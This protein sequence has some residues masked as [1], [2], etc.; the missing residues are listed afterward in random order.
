MTVVYSQ[1][2]KFYAQSARGFISEVTTYPLVEAGRQAAFMARVA[3]VEMKFLMGI[4]AG[5]SGVG[6]ALVI[7]T[8]VAEF[9]VQNRENFLKW[10]SQLEAVLKAREFLKAY[11]PKLYEKVFNAVLRQLYKDVKSKFPD[12]VTPETV[13]FGVGVILGS[14]GKKLA[15]GKFSIFLLV[16]V[17]LEQIVIR[18]SP[19]VLP[20]AFKLTAE[21][22]NKLAE[23]IIRKMREAGVFMTNVDVKNIVEEVKRH[24][25]QVKKAFKMLQEVFGRGR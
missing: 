3:I 10:K 21:E 15:A 25:E 1:N 16:F 18:S 20:G 14:V 17:V 11:A 7:G 2:R 24:P 19:N 8:E 13:A 12:A 23:E 5:S 9:M 22:Y 4:V 6:F